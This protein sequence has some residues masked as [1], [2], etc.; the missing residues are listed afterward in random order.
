MVKFLTKTTANQTDY[1]KHWKK[2]FTHHSSLVDDSV[3]DI[4]LL[5]ESVTHSLWWQKYQCFGV[6]FWHLPLTAPRWLCV[7]KTIGKEQPRSMNFDYSITAPLQNKT[8][9]SEAS[10]TL[11]SRFIFWLSQE[12]RVCFIF[13]LVYIHQFIQDLPNLLHCI[14]QC[15]QLLNCVSRWFIAHL[16]ALAK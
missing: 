10:G 11:H 7:E 14:G 4:I 3:G 12:H 2:E 6:F 9:L 5:N 15:E 8:S 13:Y 1:L 16:K